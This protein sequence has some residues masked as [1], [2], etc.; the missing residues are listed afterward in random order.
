MATEL[1]NTQNDRIA[2]TPEGQTFEIAK[3][4]T[5]EAAHRLPGRGSGDPYGRIHG[6][7]FKVE[8]VVAGR[9]KPGE[10]WVEDL[11]TLSAALQSIADEL[12]H[13]LLNE[14]DGLSAPTFEVIAMWIADRLKPKF[15]G[16]TCL[17]ISRPSLNEE[18]TLRL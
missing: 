13:Q 7:S 1:T 3:S 8:A 2:L 6:H 9:V 4:V 12:D 18:C 17:T 5:F 14:I 10:K 11:G 16:L 15:P